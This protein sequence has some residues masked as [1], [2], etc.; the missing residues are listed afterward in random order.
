MS[1]VTVKNLFCVFE[2][3]SLFEWPFSLCAVFNSLFHHILLRHHSLQFGF[4]A[5]AYLVH[6]TRL[7]RSS[8]VLHVVRYGRCCENIQ[9]L[10]K[11]NI[12]NSRKKIKKKQKRWDFAEQSLLMKCFARSLI[13]ICCPATERSTSMSNKWSTLKNFHIMLL[14]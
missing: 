7:F 11:W 14:R 4:M 9:N 8:L 3:F 6:L 13:S 5:A 1:A 2:K 12:Q 10:S